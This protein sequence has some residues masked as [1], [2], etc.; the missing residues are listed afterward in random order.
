MNAA[1]IAAGLV[2]TSLSFY[3]EDLA[4]HDAM[5]DVIARIVMQRFRDARSAKSSNRIYQG[6]STIQLLSEADHSMAKEYTP[7]QRELLAQAFGTC[8]SRFY[9]VAQAK[10]TAI[11]DWKTE[12]VAG[13]PGSLIQ[14][15]PT[16]E[17]PVAG[18]VG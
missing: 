17:P 11:S 16:P 9:G 6:K 10:T 13:D 12:L 2:P 18:G 14:I 8:P 4:P 7:A 15:E 1:P 3:E 5:D